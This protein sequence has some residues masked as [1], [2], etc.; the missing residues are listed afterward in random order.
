M[1]IGVM[2]VR[3]RRDTK[4][5][6]SERERG[7]ICLINAAKGPKAKFLI[8]A[9]K[10]G[11]WVIQSHP[12]FD[13]QIISVVSG[14]LPSI[15]PAR[16]L[17]TFSLVELPPP[18]PQQCPPREHRGYNNRR[19]ADDCP[20]KARSITQLHGF[21]IIECAMEVKILLFPPRSAK[22]FL[23]LID[24]GTD[25]RLALIRRIFPR[26]PG[27][28]REKVSRSK[29]SNYRNNSGRP[30]YTSEPA[31]RRLLFFVISINPHPAERRQ[32]LI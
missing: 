3:G 10:F 13:H 29:E 2:R 28:W 21:S 27:G 8:N 17:P 1:F 7:W 11:Q 16:T 24:A 6:A 30:Y 19:G 22:Y 4:T 25:R 9:R 5:R 12:P 23:L 18:Q 32:W 31:R 26:C 15:P 14:I 20:N